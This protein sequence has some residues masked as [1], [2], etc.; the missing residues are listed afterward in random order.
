MAK[1]IEF[2]DSGEWHEKKPMY[3]ILNKKLGDVMGMVFWYP[4]WRQFVCR[5]KDDCIWSADCLKDVQE[6][7][8]GPPKIEAATKDSP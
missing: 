8:E 7:I 5:F 1:F 2:K 3:D 6:F 4:P